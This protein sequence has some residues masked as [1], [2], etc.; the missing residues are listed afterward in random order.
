MAQRNWSPVRLRPYT[1]AQIARIIERYGFRVNWG[2]G[3]E[4]ARVTGGNL[5][6]PVLLPRPH[7]GRRLR[8]DQVRYLLDEL[9]IPIERL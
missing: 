6:R 1:S 7:G 4:A 3:K 2:M 9:G 8:E 5:R